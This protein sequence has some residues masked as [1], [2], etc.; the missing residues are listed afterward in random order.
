MTDG[1]YVSAIPASEELRKSHP[2]V[3]GRLEVTTSEF[4]GEEWPVFTV[5]ALYADGDDCPIEVQ[6]EGMLDASERRVKPTVFPLPGE[7]E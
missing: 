1:N 2:R 7:E 5:H 3:T 4:M 6:E